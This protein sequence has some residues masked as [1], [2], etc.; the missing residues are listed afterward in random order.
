[1][2]GSRYQLDDD[3]EPLT[4]TSKHKADLKAAAM[5]VEWSLE[6]ATYVQQV[7]H[8]GSLSGTGGP[9]EAFSLEASGIEILDAAIRT[10][11][12]ERASQQSGVMKAVFDAGAQMIILAEEA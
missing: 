3:F 12:R 2:P 9:I 5:Q 6:P 1:M 11:S 4:S 10:A 8:S 7:L